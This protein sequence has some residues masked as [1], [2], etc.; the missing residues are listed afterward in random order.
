MNFDIINSE[1]RVRLIGFRGQVP[2]NCFGEVGKRLMDRLWAEVRGRGIKSTGINHWVYLPRSEMFTGVEPVGDIGDVGPL[3][4]L[5]VVLTRHVRHVHKGPYTALPAVW[6]QLKA[7][8]QQAGESPGTPG[9]EI[10]GH[11][12]ENPSDLETTI[13]L[14]LANTQSQ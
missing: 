12:C 14:A 11:W 13:L 1:F 5:E 9:L 6:S 7:A 4:S 3:E 2:N 10:Y 8:L